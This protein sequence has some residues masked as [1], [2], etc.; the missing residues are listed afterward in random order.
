[1]RIGL[2]AFVLLLLI[3]AETKPKC[4]VKK[5]KAAVFT[6]YKTLAWIA[7]FDTVRGKHDKQR[8]YEHFIVEQV[9]K[10]M[11]A[12]G[13]TLD[14]IHPDIVLMYDARVNHEEIQKQTP[15]TTVSVG[16]YMPYYYGT[17]YYGGYYFDPEGY[18]NQNY[19]PINSVGYYGGYYIQATQPAN[20]SKPPTKYVV[21]EGNIVFN[22]FDT[23]TKQVIWSAG[24]KEKVNI[25]TDLGS[26]LKTVIEA[27]WSKFPQK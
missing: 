19:Y 2:L 17:N 25:E 11:L 26:D 24:A 23:K 14:S 22:V 3:S 9:D 4:F 7:P 6:N 12:K 21:E 27:A 20:S 5:N 15:T 1:M 8:P 13:Y 10:Q 16:V 18:R